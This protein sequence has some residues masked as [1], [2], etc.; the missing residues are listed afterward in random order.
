MVS[1][2]EISRRNDNRID[3]LEAAMLNNFDVVECPLKHTFTPGLYIREIFMPKDSVITSKIHKT[4]HPFIVSKGVVSVSIDAGEWQLIEAPYSGITKPGTRR[5][6]WVH[7][8]TIWTTIHANPDNENENEIEERI[9]EKHE[10]PLLN[11]KEK[12]RLT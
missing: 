11:I 7:E 3:K 6:L 5:I 4:E 2:T 8:D 12:E 10:N 1:E 9:I